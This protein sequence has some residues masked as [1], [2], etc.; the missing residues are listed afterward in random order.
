VFQPGDLFQAPSRPALV[1]RRPGFGLALFTSGGKLSSLKGAHGHEA[2]RSQA[3]AQLNFQSVTMDLFGRISSRAD[4][5]P[6]QM[7]A[8]TSM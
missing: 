4:V 3:F 2:L 1:P 8:S 7:F 5:G 6:A